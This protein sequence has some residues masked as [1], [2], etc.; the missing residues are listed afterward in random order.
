M[1]W[2]SI[3]FLTLYKLKCYEAGIIPSVDPK[4]IKI[5]LTS[6]SEQDSRKVRRK[7]RK[8]WRS[9]DKEKLRASCLLERS[10]P[11]LQISFD[12]RSAVLSQLALEINNLLDSSD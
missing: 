6:L 4:K 5:A 10:A 12:R 3:K 7:F 8:M 1:A 2:S 9:L 11:T